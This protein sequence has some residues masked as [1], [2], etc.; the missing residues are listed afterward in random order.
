VDIRPLLRTGRNVIAVRAEN[1]GGPAGLLVEARIGC[2][3]VTSDKTWRTSDKEDPDWQ[4]PGFDDARWAAAEEI[5]PVPISPW[6][7]VSNGPP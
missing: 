2:L 6:G 1:T 7:D 3:T 4:Q 5:G